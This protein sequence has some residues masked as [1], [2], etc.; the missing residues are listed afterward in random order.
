MNTEGEY[1]GGKRQI[2]TMCP[3]NCL[4]TQ[5]GMTVTVEGNTLVSVKGDA[6]NPDSRGFLGVS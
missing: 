5:C 3:M 4:P 6:H 1:M 2:T